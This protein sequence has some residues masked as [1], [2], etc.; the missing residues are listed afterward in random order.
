MGV[1]DD[2]TPVTGCVRTHVGTDEYYLHSDR[3][4]CKFCAQ[5][6]ILHIRFL[7]IVYLLFEYSTML[8]LEQRN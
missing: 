3:Q 8:R 2:C 6:D 1:G 4:Q 7:H 5:L